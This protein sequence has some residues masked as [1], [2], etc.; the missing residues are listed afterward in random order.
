MH[1]FSRIEL[2]I[3]GKCCLDGTS[4]VGRF[5]GS[6]SGI[7]LDAVGTLIEPVPSVAEAYCE[8]AQ[9]Q[10]VTLDIDLVRTRF[11][12]VFSA[13]EKGGAEPRWV[14]DEAIERIR[15]LRIVA[16]VLPEL[17]DL[18]AGFDRLWRHFAE[19][20]S[21]RPFDDAEQFLDL[22]QNAGL[23]CCVASNFDSRLR[24]I[25]RGLP[26]LRKLEESAV[27]SSEVFFRKPH[28]S[29][30][31]AAAARVGLSAS[32]LLFVGDD[33]RNDVEGPLAAGFGGAILLDRR[34]RRR[35]IEPRARTLIEVAGRLGFGVG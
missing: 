12:S 11:S 3:G 33:P 15:W 14:T 30:Y 9:T 22:A 7:V 21:W 5:D 19:P 8:T 26:P 35:T 10:G 4:S 28:P 24:R 17:P 20:E 34:D 18:E 16:A 13:D 31:Q 6:F 27:I 23:V 32:K 2:L 1:A 25:L 29:F